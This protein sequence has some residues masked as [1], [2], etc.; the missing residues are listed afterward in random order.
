VNT[1]QA[2]PNLYAFFTPGELLARIRALLRHRSSSPGDQVISIGT[3]VVDFAGRTVTK[4]N[5]PIKL[6]PT[7]YSLL[8]LFLQNAG[9]VLTHT[10]ILQTVGDHRMLKRRST[11]VCLL[12][13]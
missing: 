5:E 9:K 7:E 8:V 6:T 2:K 12:D 3:I 10:Y 1:L 4:N 13:N 11:C